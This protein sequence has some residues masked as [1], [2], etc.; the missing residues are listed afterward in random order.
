MR[1]KVS[2]VGLNAI[3]AV[4]ASDQP[5]REEHSHE[6]QGGQ[7]HP[8]ALLCQHHVQLCQ[9]NPQQEDSEQVMIFLAC[10]KVRGGD[11]PA[12]QN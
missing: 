8:P 4:K 5:V 10:L 11:L 7:L 3:I 12:E 2:K 1:C 9:G 6:A